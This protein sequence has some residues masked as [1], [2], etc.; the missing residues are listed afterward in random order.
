[1]YSESEMDIEIMGSDLGREE[2]RGVPG[3]SRA[4]AKFKYGNKHSEYHGLNRIL[5][6]KLLQRYNPKS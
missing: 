3:S 6:P 1:M 5:C 2:E 4:W